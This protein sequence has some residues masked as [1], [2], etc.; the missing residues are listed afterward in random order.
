MVSAHRPQGGVNSPVGIAPL[1]G[2]A[3]V[4]AVLVVAVGPGSGQILVV[5]GAA[6]AA[7]LLAVVTIASVSSK[8]MQRERFLSNA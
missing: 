6:S 8:R 2:I 5:V 1:L 4:L 7:M 3:P